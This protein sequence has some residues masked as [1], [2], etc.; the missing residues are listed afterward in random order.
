MK[1]EIAVLGA[2]G[3]L[4]GNLIHGLRLKYSILG[5]TRAGKDG[6]ALA[7]TSSD[8]EIHLI[9]DQLKPG[10][11]VINTIGKLTNSIDELNSDDVS[12]A[13]LVNGKF[14]PRLSKIAFDRGLRFIHI[15]TDAIFSNNVGNV[16]ENSLT[17]PQGVYG[18]SKLLGEVSGS[19]AITIRCSFVG[20]AAGLNKSGLWSWVEH[21]NQGEVISGF[22]N[23]LWSGVTTNQL[24]YLCDLLADNRIFHE[25][26]TVSSIHHFCPNPA[27]TKYDLVSLIATQ[28]RPDIITLPKK[29]DMA[30]TRNLL[31]K[32][33]SLNKLF[34]NHELIWKSLIR[35]A[36]LGYKN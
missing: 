19:N 12:D 2:Q 11:L 34:D 26:A 21:L 6:A 8:E 23:H 5:T 20:P 35:E 15:S 31:S 9:F 29:H 7:V 3:F 32:F 18:K 25:V 27:I 16:D 22:Q 10:A 30:I 1:Y 14:P 13:M 17:S 36:A 4:G 24:I 33:N 28:I